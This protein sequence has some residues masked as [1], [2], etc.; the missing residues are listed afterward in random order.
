MRNHKMCWFDV[1]IC[2]YIMN[3]LF[4][5]KCR[6]NRRLSLIEDIQP[7]TGYTNLLNNKIKFN[8]LVGD[9][10]NYLLR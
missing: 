1:C 2:T 7:D 4:R 8:R 10:T 3:C 9:K 6:F 5:L